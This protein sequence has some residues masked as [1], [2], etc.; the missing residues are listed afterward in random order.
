MYCLTNLPHDTLLFTHYVPSEGD[1]FL[2]LEFAKI[3]SFLG[4][5]VAVLFFLE[6]SF[7][8]FFYTR[9]SL[10][11]PIVNHVLLPQVLL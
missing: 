2:S 7:H 3:T 9:D 5:A 4:I 1:L 10:I 8:F 11:F 6:F